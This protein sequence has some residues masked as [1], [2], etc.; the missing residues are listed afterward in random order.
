MSYSS[1][2]TESKHLCSL[3]NRNLVSLRA[4]SKSEL[5]P[6][7]NTEEYHTIGLIEKYET[8]QKVQKTA[9]YY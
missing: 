4:S 1:K 3:I 7:N 9:S 8:E 6:V 5:L 2:D